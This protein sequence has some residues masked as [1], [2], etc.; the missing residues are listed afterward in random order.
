VSLSAFT[1]RTPHGFRYDHSFV[2]ELVTASSPDFHTVVIEYSDLTVFPGVSNHW[3]ARD[4]V[5]KDYGR[6]PP[7]IL[8]D[9]RFAGARWY[10]LS[11]PVDQGRHLDEYGSIV[12][13]GGLPRLA[14]V[15]IENAAPGAARRRHLVDSVLATV[16]IKPAYHPK[17]T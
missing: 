4:A 17:E 15:S 1:A 10:H 11:G 6:H 13:K 8:D 7:K 12:V 14:V 16:R 3:L 9:V 2:Q 5:R